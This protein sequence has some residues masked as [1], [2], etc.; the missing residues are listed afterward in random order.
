MPRDRSRE[1]NI[2]LGATFPQT[3]SSE[4]VAIPAGAAGVVV[5]FYISKR[6]ILDSKNSYVGGKGDTSLALTSTAFTSEVSSNKED[7]ELANGDFWIDYV[8]GRGR[9][10]KADSST[11]MT[12]TYRVLTALLGAT[13]QSGTDAT[14]ADTY[15]TV[16]TPSANFSRISITNEGANAAIVSIDGG[17]TDTFIR[18]PGGFA[19]TFHAAIRSGVAIQ[20]KNASAGNNY[21]NLTVTVD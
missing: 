13:P 8:T 3:I 9:G 16:L 19:G 5:D 7:S 6:P 17:T 15:A 1:V 18:I 11:T 4:T 20:A 14:G 2:S 10:K 21:S 12:A